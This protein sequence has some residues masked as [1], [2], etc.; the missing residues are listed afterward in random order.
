MIFDYPSYYYEDLSIYEASEPTPT[1]QPYCVFIIKEENKESTSGFSY[2]I[3]QTIYA[4][5]EE[6]EKNCKSE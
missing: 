2:R 1:A 6:K 5:K 3:F 4:T